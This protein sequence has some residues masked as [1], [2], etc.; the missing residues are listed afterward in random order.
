MLEIKAPASMGKGAKG[1]RI[2]KERMRLGLSQPKFAEACGV[3]K[4]TQ[5]NYEKGENSPD[6]E[7][8]SKA[9][10]LGVDY[11]YVMTGI[12]SPKK[13]ESALL[14]LSVDVELLKNC[15][16]LLEEV[17]VET[18]KSLSAQQKAKLVSV[19]YQDWVED[20]EAATAKTIIKHLRLVA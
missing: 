1:Q 8:L 5:I 11:I 20:G 10:E 12:A 17:L 3:G 9:S 14:T 19:L 7:Y 4:N 6:L 15:I 2:K 18:G 16:E 13:E